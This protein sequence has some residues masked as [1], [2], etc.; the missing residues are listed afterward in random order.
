MFKSFTKSYNI[1]NIKSNINTLYEKA[2]YLVAIDQEKAVSVLATKVRLSVCLTKVRQNTFT[3]FHKNLDEDTLNK[4]K[5][6]FIS[7]CLKMVAVY[8]KMA[9]AE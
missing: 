9:P 6:E 1:F 7:T 8:Y 4:T 2:L 5:L 3:G